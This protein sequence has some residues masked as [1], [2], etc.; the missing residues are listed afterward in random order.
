MELEK[1][2]A[3]PRVI[4]AKAAPLA[5]PEENTVKSTTDI[6]T[7]AEPST[8]MEKEEKNVTT[9]AGEVPQDSQGAPSG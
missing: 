7:E 4:K 5:E 8:S 3:K 1:K 9:Q 6:I 2:P